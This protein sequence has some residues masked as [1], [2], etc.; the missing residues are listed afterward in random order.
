MKFVE[1]VVGLNARQGTIRLWLATQWG[2]NHRLPH[3]HQGN[4]LPA[5]ERIAERLPRSVPTA[6][7]EALPGA[8]SP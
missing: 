1:R 3:R 5:G 6:F 2:R 4:P 8:T 7:I